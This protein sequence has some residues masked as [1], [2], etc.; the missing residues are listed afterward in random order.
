[1]VL[2]S[3]IFVIMSFIALNISKARSYDVLLMRVGD[4]LVMADVD[5]H[6]QTTLFEYDSIGRYSNPVWSPDGNRILLSSVDFTERGLYVI[7]LQ[8][9][10]TT[11]L[12]NDLNFGIL[13]PSWSPDGQFIAFSSFIDLSV[14]GELYTINVETRELINWTQSPVITDRGGWWSPDGQWLAYF[15]TTFAQSTLNIVNTTTHVHTELATFDTGSIDLLWSPDSTQIAVSSGSAVWLVDIDGSASLN[16][17]ISIAAP[18]YLPSWSPDGRSI[19]VTI[20][21]TSLDSEI[22]LVDL[23][24]QTWKYLTN[25]LAAN[26]RP[27]WT[28]D[29]EQIVFLSNRGGTYQFYTMNQDGSNVSQLTNF[30]GV[31]RRYDFRP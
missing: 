22:V 2:F 17:L 11:N 21:T 8:D 3:L 6:I 16:R 1:M 14:D 10:T 29:G 5:Q 31:A 12:A 20:A 15:T 30:A 28:S 7:N 9:G 23:E 18:V 4:T 25:D 19:L 27:L 26:T 13:S 24:T